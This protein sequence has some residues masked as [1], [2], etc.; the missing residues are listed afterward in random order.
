VVK[1][2]YTHLFRP[3]RP[4][5]RGDIQCWQHDL[6]SA[7]HG[8]EVRRGG[9][10]TFQTCR[11]NEAPDGAPSRPVSPVD[12]GREA[13]LALLVLGSTPRTLPAATAGALLAGRPLIFISAVL[14][15]VIA[16]VPKSPAKSPLPTSAA[17]S[18]SFI[19]PPDPACDARFRPRLGLLV[20]RRMA[21][22]AFRPDGNYPGRNES[23]QP[24][25]CGVSKLRPC[26]RWG[27]NDEFWDGL[28]V[29]GLRRSAAWMVALRT[30]LGHWQRHKIHHCK[31]SR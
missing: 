30:P 3:P 21:R 22:A 31:I 19:S 25:L 5:R 9:G 23:K 28:R 11:A 8:P 18:P 10:R 2:V 15:T 17:T 7:P 16:A 12:Q 27:R 1:G 20:R 14:D 6:L 13:G 29:R 24:F 4:E 26:Y